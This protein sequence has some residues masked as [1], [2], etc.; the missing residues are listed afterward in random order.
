MLFSYS[1]NLTVLVE[2]SHYDLSVGVISIPSMRASI[3]IR[4]EL[5]EGEKSKYLYIYI[6]LVGV[7]S[8]GV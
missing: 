1:G 3:C 4:W 7:I 8:P 5:I 6:V 2:L